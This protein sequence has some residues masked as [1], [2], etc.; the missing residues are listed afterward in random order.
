[1]GDVVQVSFMGSNGEAYTYTGTVVG[2]TPLKDLHSGVETD[3][4]L[5][6]VQCAHCRVVESVP[7]RHVEPVKAKDTD[8]RL[9]SVGGGA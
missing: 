9:N 3:K 8:P 2:F 7:E 5:V 6:A 1:M 4:Y